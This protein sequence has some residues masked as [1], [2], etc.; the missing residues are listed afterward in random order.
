MCFVLPVAL[1]LPGDGA[2]RVRGAALYLLAPAEV[3][4]VL[5]QACLFPHTYL[6]ASGCCLTEPRVWIRLFHY[7]KGY[8]LNCK[9]EEPSRCC[10]YL[11]CIQR[12]EMVW[13]L[14]FCHLLT[15]VNVKVSGSLTGAG[16]WLC[17]LWHQK[18]VPAAEDAETCSYRSFGTAEKEPGQHQGRL[19]S[20]GENHS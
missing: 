9:C 14:V 10:S 17:L 12:S 8:L 3:I 19:E 6:I 15:R 4:R 1:F 5:Y 11:K 13:C 18:Y 2:L 16:A 7:L 20:A